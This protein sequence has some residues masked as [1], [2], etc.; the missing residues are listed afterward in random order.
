MKEKHALLEKFNL[1]SDNFPHVIDLSL[2]RILNLL[3]KMGNPHLNLPPII[4]VAGTN[5]KGSTIQFIASILKAAGKILHIYTSPH[6]VTINERLIVSNN[7]VT[8]E[9]LSNALA[10]CLK[11]KQS[12]SITQFELL[13]CMSFYI[14]AKNTADFAII[15]TGLGGRLDATNVHP[16]PI[17][18]IITPIS[19]DHEQ[20][21]GNNIKNIAKEKAGI[22]KEGVKCVSSNQMRIVEKNLEAVANKKKSKLLVCGR[23]WNYKKFNNGFKLYENKKDSLYSLPFMEGDHQIENAAL[24]IFSLKQINSLKIS[25]ININ[26]G[27]LKARWHGRLEKLNKGYIKNLLP[28]DSEVWLDGGH[29]VAAAIAI[30]NWLKINNKK[31]SKKKIIFICAFLKTKSVKKILKIL[32]SQIDKVIFVEMSEFDNF[33]SVKKLTEIANTLQID[34]TNRSSISDAFKSV[35][36]FRSNKVII[37]GSLYL[38]GEVK[39]INDYAI[40]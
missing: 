5:G 13:T 31:N 32:S 11:I 36:Y 27:L 29:N 38:I 18:T 17:L 2:D 4:H 24:A 33:Y 3:S 39:K 8:D 40:C 7:Q 6:L 20:F 14:M 25:K 26:N 30:K 21:L 10:F 15:E 1:I 37:F 16:E 23:D 22:I 28:K 35:E 19:Y 12:D 34:N 9:Q